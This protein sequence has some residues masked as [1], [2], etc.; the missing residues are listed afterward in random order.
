MELQGKVAL[1]T[2]AAQGIG[3]AIA[4]ILLKNGAKVSLLDINVPTGE[5]TKAAFEQVYGA[6]NIL[7]LPCDVTSENQLK[8]CFGKT[9]EKFQRLDIVCNNAG[10][11]DRE[12][13]EKCLS[14]NLVSVIKGTFLGIQHMSKETGGKGG[15]IVNIASMA[16]LIPFFLGPVY[17]A[18][19]YGVV[20]FT[21]SLS[22]TCLEKHGVR[23][24]VLCPGF[25]DTPLLTGLKSVKAPDQ[26]EWFKKMA[27][28]FG[29][30][31]TSQTAEG[32]LQ[33][34]MDHT[35]NGALLKASENGKLEYED[36]PALVLLE[37]PKS[38]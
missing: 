24:Q 20:G 17:A 6:E 9:L 19:K 16:G 25:V 37:N 13:W 5:A 30:Q 33:L 27:A 35:R 32:F 15:V 11:S 26:K 1:V 23:L 18:S 12:N 31:T 8:D 22:L 29:V 34:V 28:R 21:T 38:T 2:G 10:I 4:E 14:V 3:K 7:F 36:L